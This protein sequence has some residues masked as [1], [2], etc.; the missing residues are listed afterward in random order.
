MSLTVEKAREANRAAAQGQADYLVDLDGNR[1]DD[2]PV[3]YGNIDEHGNVLFLDEERRARKEQ[4]E[5]PVFQNHSNGLGIKNFLVT[6]LSARDW[7]WNIVLALFRKIVKWS[8]FMREPDSFKSKL[9]KKAMLFEPQM[10]TYSS[11]SIYNLNVTTENNDVIPGTAAYNDIV[12]SQAVEE[13]DHGHGHGHGDDDCP[14][15]RTV[16]LEMGQTVAK[17]A[18]KVTVPLD[19]V[20][21]AIEEA[22]FIGGMNQCLCRSGN[23][24]QNYPHDLACLFLNMGGRVIVEHG[25]GVELTREQ[26]LARVDKAAELGLACQSLWVEIEQLIWGFRNDEMNQFMEICFC[27]PCCCVALNLSHNATRD[28]KRRFSPAGWTAVV[29]HDACTGCKH[30]LDTYCPQDAIHYRASDGKMVVDQENCVGCGICRTH[31]PEG[32]I[33]IK[34]TMPM[35]DDM[36]DYFY[37][38]GRLDIVPGEGIR[39][40][41]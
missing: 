10:G 28:V 41:A 2:L 38:E 29:N 27:C 1:V 36:H 33:D 4:P 13:H 31:C 32:A 39:R 22:E 15:R 7:N 17:D 24:C 16:R 19:L 21:K 35:R 26:A 20:K 6:H 11:G 23:D 3:A 8:A 25:M 40:G 30:C 5:K 12:R 37:E 18:S 14:G 9:Y 34:Q